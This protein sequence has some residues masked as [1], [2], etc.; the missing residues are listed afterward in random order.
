[1]MKKSPSAG[2]S[3]VRIGPARRFFQSLTL[4]P[5]VP[6]A[7]LPGSV[8]GSYLVLLTPLRGAMGGM[9]EGVGQA[10]V[11]SGQEEGRY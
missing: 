11:V 9:G 3:C 10:E 6:T 2:R 5:L 8:P 7:S 4:I 1:M